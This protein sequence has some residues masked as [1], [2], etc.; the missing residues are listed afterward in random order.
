MG[1]LR[2][3]TMVLIV[4]DGLMSRWHL[5]A[6]LSGL[7]DRRHNEHGDDQREERHHPP[8]SRH[9]GRH[10]CR[11]A[12][13]TKDGYRERLRFWCAL[14]EPH[15]PAEPQFACERLDSA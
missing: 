15:F 11:L 14:R 9:L 2:L 6:A 7:D 1:G 13:S 10:H 12:D 3:R 8:G 5:D 4:V